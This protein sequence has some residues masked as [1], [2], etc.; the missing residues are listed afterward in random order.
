M[1]AEPK[2]S[3]L[4]VALLIFLCAFMALEVWI[5]FKESSI[6]FPTKNCNMSFVKNVFVC[7]SAK[8]SIKKY[9]TVANQL[10]F[11]RDFTINCNRLESIT[12]NDHCF[13]NN[14]RSIRRILHFSEF[15]VNLFIINYNQTI[16]NFCQNGW[17]FAMIGNSN[18]GLINSFFNTFNRLPLLALRVRFYCYEN[19]GSFGMDLGF[20]TSPHLNALIDGHDGQN[21][22]DNS[23]IPSI[24][25]EQVVTRRFFLAIISFLIFFSLSLLGSY[26]FDNE[27]RFFGAALIGFGF[28]VFLGSLYLGWVTPYSWSWGWPL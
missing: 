3:K 27:W 15:F 11:S 16:I 2:A 22:G 21:S 18:L 12:R 23:Q 4:A 20:N 17:C 6:M 9:I 13:W 7:N 8:T 10:I 19:I 25:Y 5:G 24:S 14:F 1:Q 26:C 28:L